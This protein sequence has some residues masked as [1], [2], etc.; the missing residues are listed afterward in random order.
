[1]PKR[2]NPDKN[3]KNLKTIRNL[4]NTR[5]KT[6]EKKKR[7]PNTRDKEGGFTKGWI[8]ISNLQFYNQTHNDIVKKYNAVI[9]TTF[10]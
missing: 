10:V 4:N 8:S 6:L 7:K 5:V 2:R 3:V 1:M 9:T